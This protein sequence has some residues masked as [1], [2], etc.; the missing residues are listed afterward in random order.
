MISLLEETQPMEGA[1]PSLLSY[2]IR[3]ESDEYHYQISTIKVAAR[4]YFY[5]NAVSSIQK[6]FTTISR[7]ELIDHKLIEFE[8]N[9]SFK[10]LNDQITRLTEEKKTDSCRYHEVVRI[11]WPI[12]IRVVKFVCSPIA[13]LSQG[14]YDSF[15][16]GLISSFNLAQVFEPETVAGTLLAEAEQA[17]RKV[18]I[19]QRPNKILEHLDEQATDIVTQNKS[20]LLICGL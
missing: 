3:S 19:H 2:L 18:P 17:C 7:T 16:S 10:L 1:L 4:N 8:K 11:C 13:N 6:L 14:K 9:E 20:L 12:V 15:L 5:Y